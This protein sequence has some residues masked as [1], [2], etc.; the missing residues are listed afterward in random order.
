[1][2]CSALLKGTRVDG[3]Y[4]AD[5]EKD[6]DAVRYDQLSYLQVL[7]EDL[8]VMDASAVSLARENNIPILVFSIEDAGGFQRVLR[9]E[10]KF[11]IVS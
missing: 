10:G 2:G 8:K 7:S 5:P 6:S 3:V 1:M 11:T 9:H 4:S